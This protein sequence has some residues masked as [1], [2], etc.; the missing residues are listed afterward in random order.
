MKKQVLLIS[1]LWFSAPIIAMEKSAIRTLPVARQSLAWELVI[2]HCLS[3]DD[4]ST[5]SL[6]VEA[7]KPTLRNSFI[8]KLYNGPMVGLHFACKI[9][10]I[11]YFLYKAAHEA[12]QEGLKGLLRDRK[13]L[14]HISDIAAAV[15]FD[16][17]ISSQVI[18]G[19]CYQ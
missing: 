6:I 14:P 17:D 1:L 15:F 9:G 2:H 4:Y 3:Q 5:I 7:I 19:P 13:C 11:N 8:D 16:F 10:V 12:G 18:E